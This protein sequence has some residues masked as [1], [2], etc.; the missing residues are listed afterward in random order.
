MT[1]RLK[2]RILQLYPDDMNIYGDRG[3]LLA[4]DRRLRQHGFEP[5]IINHN[6]GDNF[7]KDVDII[8]GGGGQD[9]GQEKIQEDLKHISNKLKILAE[10]GTPMLVICG[11][12]QLFGNQFITSQSKTIKGIGILNVETIAGNERL[13]GNI[14]ITSD[15]FGDII[16]YENH[17]GQTYLGENTEPLGYVTLGEGNNLHDKSEGA[18]YK[19]IIG[20]YLHGSLLPKNPR[21]TDFLIQ[22]AAINRYGKFIPAEIDDGLIEKAR[23]SAMS[24]PR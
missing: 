9:S 6:I 4:L 2:L 7:N 17:S 18:L 12:Y 16:G 8:I 5:E 14:K 10:N 23:V 24:R 3:N 13:I 22:Q 21:I 20:T 1:D 11:M 19:N 15:K